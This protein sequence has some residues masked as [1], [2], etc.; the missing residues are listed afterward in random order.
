MDA[1]GAS[2][3]YFVAGEGRPVVL[4]HGLGGAASNW[5]SLAPALA[6]RARVIVPEFPGHGGSS[7]LPVP[8]GVE[9]FADRVGLLLEA[10]RA[11]RAV[12]VGHSFGGATAIA[13]AVRRPELVGGLVLAAAAGISSTGRRARYML[14]FSFLVKPGKL[15][16]PYRSRIARSPALRRLAFGG[17]AARD[18]EAMSAEAAEGFLAGP[19]LHTDTAT[20]GRSLFGWDVRDRLA[21]VTC[22]S[23]VLW[24]ARDPQLPVSDAIDFAR[25]LRAPLRVI[26]GCGHL[27]IGERP[28]ACLDAI[29]GFLD[30]VGE[31]DELPGEA[32]ALRQVSG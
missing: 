19:A 12:L 17:W 30:G 20:A 13:L 27:L 31:L 8:V 16:A 32:E 26:A 5:R 7:P 24:G 23:L 11:E 1:R 15:I 25:R 6:Q 3:R 2:M 10:E 4:L 21:S 18:P 9:G 22:P 14:E 28:D 29:E